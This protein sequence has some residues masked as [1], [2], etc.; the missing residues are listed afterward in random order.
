MHQPAHTPSDSPPGLQRFVDAAR[1]QPIVATCVSAEAVAAG[2]AEHQRRTQTRR[3]LL[4]SAGMAV[5]ASVVAVGI[6]WPLWSASDGQESR[7]T[8]SAVVDGETR[9]D[10]APTPGSELLASAV[11]LR[12][13]A[14]VE[15]RGAWSIALH[16]GTHEI[17]VDPVPGHALEIDLP[18]RVLELIEGAVTVEFV[19]DEAAV[20]LHNGVASWVDEDGQRAQISVEQLLEPS[21]ES[22]EADANRPLVP[23]AAE[24]ARSAEQLLAAGKRDEAIAI[25]RQLVRKHPRASQTRAAV[26]DLARLLRVED[27]EDEAR[28]AYRLYLERWPESSVRSEVESQLER[29]GPG[30]R[31]RGLTPG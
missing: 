25:Y 28:C 8:A 17:E 5:A 23:T 18:D 21:A 22:D 6:L 13:T 10:T 24:L 3:S 29:L 15:V 9:D 1:E 30:P 7:D 26:L 11:R 12:S 19:G 14:P 27:H 20:R 2:L 4:L 16:E 31:C